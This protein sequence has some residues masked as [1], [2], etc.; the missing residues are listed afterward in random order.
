[1]KIALVGGAVRDELLGR[2][3][4][5]RDYVVVG[6]TIEEMLSLGYKQVGKDFPVF[7]HPETGEEYEQVDDRLLNVI[8]TMVSFSVKYGSAEKAIDGWFNALAQEYI[9][10]DNLAKNKD[11]KVVID[12]IS[13]GFLIKATDKLTDDGRNIIQ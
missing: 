11:S 10:A 5:D 8:K 7:I 3:I 2:E 1:M 12:T 13:D 4:H 9:A 6:S